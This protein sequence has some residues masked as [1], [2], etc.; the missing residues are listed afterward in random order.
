MRPLLL[1]G[2]LG[3]FAGNSQATYTTQGAGGAALSKHI[4]SILRDRAGSFWFGTDGEGLCRYDG[5]HLTC[6]TEKEGLCSNFIQVLLEDK[7]GNLWLGT[8]DGICRYDGKSF[9]RLA[10]EE[11]PRDDGYPDKVRQHPSGNLWFG[12]NGGAYRYDGRSLAYFPLPEAG[13][14][15]PFLPGRYPQN[16]SPFSVYSILEDR[17]GN[18]WFG[19]ESRGVCRYDGKSFTYFT[20]KG[21][22]AAAVRTIFQ[23]KVGDLWFGNNGGG[24]YRYDGKS[25]VNFTNENGLS[26]P[27]FLKTLEGKAGTLARVWTIAEDK[28]GNLWF[29]TIDAGAW[30]Y[31]GKTL[32]NFTVKDGLGSNAIWTIYKDKTGA[33]WFGTDGGGVSK[34]DGRS[35]VSAGWD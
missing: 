28:A 31:D 25:L 29:G 9:T 24:A 3:L 15:S 20:E 30:R 10:V 4:R 16:H 11:G 33:L 1:I 5:K 7:A 12:A 2:L 8:R 14:E 26:N 34:F 23:D 22:G 35:F 27:D 32:T 6:L 18:L 13:G 17:S 21:L 19:T